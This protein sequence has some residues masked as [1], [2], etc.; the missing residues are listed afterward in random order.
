MNNFHLDQS[1]YESSHNSWASAASHYCHELNYPVHYEGIDWKQAC[2]DHGFH[3]AIQ[4]VKAA[5]RL[6][7]YQQR[8]G[9]S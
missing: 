7:Q 1:G 9:Q 4:K 6:R 8:I 5:Y 3:G 2:K